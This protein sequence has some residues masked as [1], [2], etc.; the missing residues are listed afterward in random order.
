M[1]SLKYILISSDAYFSMLHLSLNKFL[2]IKRF[3]IS[4]N[5]LISFK[6]LSPKIEKANIPAGFKNSDKSEIVLYISLHNCNEAFGIIKSYLSFNLI[7]SISPSINSKSEIIL[8]IYFFV[9][10]TIS[11]QAY[12]SNLM[13]LISS[14]VKIPVP[15]PVSKT[16]P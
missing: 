2:S 9:S 5:S 1:G 13:F 16:L 7:S 12:L 3:S 11:L 10:G 4:K 6:F 15:A 8:P 14:L